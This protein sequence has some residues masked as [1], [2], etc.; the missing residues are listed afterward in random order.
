MAGAASPAKLTPGRGRRREH[1][2]RKGPSFLRFRAQAGVPVPAHCSRTPGRGEGLRGI[3]EVGGATL[4]NPEVGRS[5]LCSQSSGV[6]RIESSSPKRPPFRLSPSGSPAAPQ[7][8]AAGAGKVQSGCPGTGPAGPRSPRGPPAPRFCNLQRT[9]RPPETPP[10]GSKLCALQRGSDPRKVCA[11]E[12]TPYLRW[13]RARPRRSGVG[14]SGSSAQPGT[15]RGVRHRRRCP[16]PS[17]AARSLRLP[18]RGEGSRSPGAGAG[19]GTSPTCGGAGPLPAARE[20]SARPLG[21]RA[22]AGSRRQLMETFP[23]GA[24][25]EQSAPASPGAAVV[26]RA[27]TGV[28]WASERAAPT[29]PPINAFPR[30]RRALANFPLRQACAL[31]LET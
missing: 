15:H 30:G 4:A 12:P 5:L 29:R 10:A 19:A 28:T 9:R 1:A 14:P 27:R 2:A 24:P 21:A 22:P 13:G 20:G 16:R 17:A 6:S 11:A 25:G 8:R 26:S 31:V 7:P 18:V 23:G 3:L